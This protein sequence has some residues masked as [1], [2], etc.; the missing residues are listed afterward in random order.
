[1]WALPPMRRTPGGLAE[2]L[3]EAEHVTRLRQGA[4]EIGYEED[5][6]AIIVRVLIVAGAT[7]AL[8]VLTAGPRDGGPG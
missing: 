7:G 5:S 1:V 8:L 2:R 6:S 4:D 3:G